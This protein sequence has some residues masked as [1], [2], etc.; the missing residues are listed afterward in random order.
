MAATQ[1]PNV[2]PFSSPFN[3]TELVELGM[4]RLGAMLDLQKDLLG[5]L[6]GIN[7]DWFARARSEAELTSALARK[8]TGVRT[9]PDATSACREWIDQRM[10]LAS[11]DSRR[12]F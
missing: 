4:S 8:L 3:P 7:R 10:H 11:E 12:L 1:S 6:E 2:N 5:T 9:L